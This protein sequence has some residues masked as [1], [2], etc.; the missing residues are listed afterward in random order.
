M[1][2]TLILQASTDEDLS[3][4]TTDRVRAELEDVV[5]QYEA[6]DEP[7]TYFQEKKDVTT[8]G[9]SVKTNL[10]ELANNPGN[11]RYLGM[12]IVGDDEL[13][14]EKFISNPAIKQEKGRDNLAFS[15][16]KQN[17]VD[18]VLLRES[19]DKIQKQIFD[20][21]DLDHD[22]APAHDLDQLRDSMT[23]L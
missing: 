10:S 22:R 4:E 20:E 23:E 19:P 5:E 12:F 6:F 17:G 9:F 14:S 1:P 2:G 7:Q 8:Y 13:I 21:I 11:G 15:I 3:E 16:L 18:K